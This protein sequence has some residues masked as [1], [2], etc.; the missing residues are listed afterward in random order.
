MIYKSYYNLW[1]N[2][3]SIALLQSVSP[4][5]PYTLPKSKKFSDRIITLTGVTGAFLLN[6]RLWEQGIFRDH[7]DG[8]ILGLQH[9]WLDHGH[10]SLEDV[11]WAFNIL[12]QA[13]AI[14]I[15]IPIDNFPI[16]N[17]ADLL[18]VSQQLIQTKITEYI[19]FHE[20]KLSQF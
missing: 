19:L 7:Y 2:D 5:K 17:P 9:Q 4:C 15:T 16:V 14:T 12:R 1:N 13:G 10:N 8:T 11:C 20:D 3:K 6:Y 18:E